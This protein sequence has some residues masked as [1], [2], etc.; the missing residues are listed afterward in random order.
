MKAEDGWVP[1]LL[2][3]HVIL[4]GRCA[5]K[6]SKVAAA[7]RAKEQEREGF[8]TAKEL[9]DERW[10]LSL[11][12]MTRADTLAKEEFEQGKIIG[13]GPAKIMVD[14]KRK[15]DLL[16]KADA[17]SRQ[18]QELMQQTQAYQLHKPD[19]RPLDPSCAQ[20]AYKISSHGR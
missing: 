9:L 7:E 6:R 10:T 8:N 16:Q 20:T 2:A 13:E 11:E 15:S 12:R 17:L 4:E 19:R 18:T 3:S 14:A 5:S 1:S